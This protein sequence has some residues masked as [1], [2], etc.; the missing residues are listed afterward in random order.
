MN[1]KFLVLVLLSVLPLW[2]VL[3]VMRS[4]KISAGNYAIAGPTLIAE[5]DPMPPPPVPPVSVLVA[6]GD[7]MPPPPVPPVTAFIA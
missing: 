2:I 1:K 7:P 3:P 4:V 5:G 6:E